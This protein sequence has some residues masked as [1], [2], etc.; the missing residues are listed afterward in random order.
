MHTPRIIYQDPWL[1]VV[2]K[3]SGLLV[4]P[5]WITPASTPNLMAL[6]KAETKAEKLHTVHRLDR[7][8]SGIMLVGKDLGAAKALQEQFMQRSVKK[9]Y[10]CVVRGWTSDEETIDYPLIPKKDK[11]AEPFAK[12]NPEPKE[13]VTR[14]HTVARVELDMPV[15]RYPR[16]RY[17]LVQAQ[18]ATGRKHQIRRHMKHILHPIIGDT[19][20]GEGRHNRLFREAFGIH[21]LLLMASSIEFT[22]PITGEEL[23]FS[24]PLSPEVQTLFD[25]LGWSEAY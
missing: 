5:S 4:H 3:P 1:L 13:A 8:T 14:Y 20:Y 6:L 7:A 16:A 19:K 12:D 15:G 17:S 9:Q 23:C 2:D 21:R 10:L 11:F 22:H 18:P 25:R 24:A